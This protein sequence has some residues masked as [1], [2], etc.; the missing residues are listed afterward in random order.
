[1][2]IEEL[3]VLTSNNKTN[4]HIILDLEIINDELVDK[5][6]NEIGIDFTG[7]VISID[8][9]SIK[10]TLHRHSDEKT[11][12]SLGQVAI[13]KEDFDLLQLIVNEA[14]RIIYD[15]RRKSEKSP[16]I[17]TLVFEK[18]IN[19]FYYVLK[20]V[21]RVSKKGKI[22]RLVLQTMYKTKKRRTW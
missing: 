7:F 22:N 14:D 21:R 13:V 6:R 9:Y 16:I 2:T 11:E 3:F 4:E 19:D 10:H 12:K 17:E 8:N 18:K 1:M 5:I 20:E 15:P